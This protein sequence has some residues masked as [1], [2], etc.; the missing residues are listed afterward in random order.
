MERSFHLSSAATY[1]GPGNRFSPACHRLR[2][3]F[4]RGSR[5]YPGGEDARRVDCR[6]PLR[7]VPGS[8]AGFAPVRRAFY[9]RPSAPGVPGAHWFYIQRA[10]PRR[11]TAV[12]LGSYKMYRRPIRCDGSACRMTLSF[13]P[14][15]WRPRIT[16]TLM[17]PSVSATASIPVFSSCRMPIS[18]P[19]F[20]RRGRYA[21]LSTRFDTGL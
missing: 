17:T 7:A 10:S 8:L 14:R 9:G 18:H 2:H 13:P 1:E 19:S 6:G 20:T 11:H 12:I 3:C 15:P 16:V 4:L 21:Q 5:F